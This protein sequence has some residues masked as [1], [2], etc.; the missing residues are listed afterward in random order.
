M[1]V[2]VAANLCRAPQHAAATTY[3]SRE[4]ISFEKPQHKVDSN[5]HTADIP[6]RSKRRLQATDLFK[7][8]L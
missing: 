6:D 3:Q 8:I 5:T 7:I 2:Q 4:R 1:G